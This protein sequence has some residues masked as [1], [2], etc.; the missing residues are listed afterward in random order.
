M[1]QPRWKILTKEHDL[2]P[3]R[4]EKRREKIIDLLLKNRGLKIKSERETFLH[5]SLDQLPKHPSL[6]KGTLQSVHTRIEKAIS[7]KEKIVIYGDYDVDGICSTGILWDFLYKKDAQVTPYIPHREGEGYGMNKETITQFATDGVKLILTCDQGINAKKEVEYAKSV[8]I[9]VIVTDHHAVPKILPDAFAIA[10]DSSLS[11]SG[12]AYLFAREFGSDENIDLA[13]L[14]TIA[15]VLP[16][17]GVN[18]VLAKFG[19]DEL[20][21]TKRPGLLALYDEAG[22]KPEIMTTYHISHVIAPRLNAMGRL[23]HAMESLRLLMTNDSDRAKRL[24]MV[25]GR[26]NLQRQNLM[27]EMYEQARVEAVKFLEAPLQ[28]IEGEA[29]PQGIIGLVAGK[30]VEEFYKPAIVLSMQENEVKGSARSIRGV[31]IVEV[32]GKCE[33]LLIDY[34][35]HPMAAGFSLERRSVTLF[36][37]RLVSLLTEQ[38][39]KEVYQKEI[40]IDCELTPQDVTLELIRDVQELAPFGMGNPEPLFV[41]KA[42]RVG[43]VRLVGS[44]QTHLKLTVDGKDAIGF[45]LAREGNIPEV[46]EKIDLV[47]SLE[48]NEWNGNSTAQLKLKDFKRSEE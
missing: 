15:D 14:G 6:L 31:N 36:R 11:G 16:L 39:G 10:H 32:I 27:N 25:V 26:T 7:S 22:I 33:D 5:P 12:V 47:F 20:R 43:S 8:G 44:D 48:K 28:F 35:G 2:P 4:G 13:A 45:G 18:R 19:L 30:L 46:G 42:F 17:V 41:G 24:A 23:E 37:E 21:K 34:G 1:L 40:T 29:W 3:V 38:V 9:D